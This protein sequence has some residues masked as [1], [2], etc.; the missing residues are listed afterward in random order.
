MIGLA[1]LVL[2]TLLGAA[3]EP[4][5]VGVARVDITPTYPI[6]LNGFGFRRAESAGVRQTIWAKALAIGDDHSGDG[7][8][9]LITADTLGIPDRLTRQLA[10]QLAA[11]GLRPGR[12]AIMATHTHTAPMIHHVSPTLF[13]MPIPPDHQTHIDRYSDE[14]AAKLLEVA[15]GALRDRRPSRLKWGIGQVGFAANRR[16]KGGPV[17]HDLPLLAVYDMS[18]QLRAVWVNYA[19]HCVTLSDNLISGDWAGYAQSEIERLHPGCT[20]LV[21][22]GCGADANPDSG[23]TGDRAD[24]AQ[25]QG[26][27][28]ASEAKRLLSISLVSLASPIV[29]RQQR[30]RLPLAELPSRERWHEL[31]AR[32]GA[33]GFHA[34]TQLARLD[35][36]EALLSEIEYPIQCWQFDGQLAMVFLP[37]E[38]V[39]DYALRL[40]RELDRHRLWINAYAN[41]CP[42]Y[43]PSERI[44]REG[45]YEGGGA[46]VYYDIP[47]PY[48]AGLE[49]AIVDVVR[50]QVGPAFAVPPDTVN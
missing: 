50:Q 19:C 39:V 22:I 2:G 29:S 43:V 21:S 41:H 32:D 10:E 30:L 34:R 13:G 8:V 33:V 31:A 9:V 12:L 7:P 36:G 49:Q 26:V 44:L 46:M 11:D 47:G 16:T 17:D 1:T 40:K 4:V 24:I 14:L 6:R 38:V 15:R 20:A 3:G 45:G 37:G 25:A 28:I 23:V 35:R 27:Q 48:A 42:G 5:S 18:D